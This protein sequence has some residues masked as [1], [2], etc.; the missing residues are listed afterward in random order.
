MNTAQKTG[1]VTTAAMTEEWFLLPEGQGRDD[2]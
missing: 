1:T 2:E